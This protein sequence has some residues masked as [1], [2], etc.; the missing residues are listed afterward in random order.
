M[1]KIMT[2]IS[3]LILIAIS[4]AVL[5]DSTLLRLYTDREKGDTKYYVINTSN[6]NY[7]QWDEDD[8]MMTII[9]SD[10]KTGE[11]KFLVPIQSNEDAE[12]FIEILMGKSANKWLDANHK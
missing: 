4:G 3:I 7:L 5:A 8:K 11:S 2:G 6:I 10:T 1:K 9:T 12:K